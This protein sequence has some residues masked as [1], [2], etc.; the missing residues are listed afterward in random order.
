MSQITYKHNSQTQTSVVRARGKGAGGGVEVGKVEVR[1]RDVCKSV[2]NE[3]KVKQKT[4]TENF[5]VQ[6][7]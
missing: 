5:R 2:N 7:T 4:T 6:K 3:N 1:N